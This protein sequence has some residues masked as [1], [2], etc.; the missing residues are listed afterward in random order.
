MGRKPSRILNDDT[1]GFGL[2]PSD[3]IGL[4]VVF[5]IL[6]TICFEIGYEGASL[7]GTL[8]ATVILIHIRLRYRRKIIRDCLRYYY[9]KVFKGG[10]FHDPKSR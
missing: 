8:L 1:L 10:V 6:Q 9:V 5:Y 2:N 3:L 7:F 4:G